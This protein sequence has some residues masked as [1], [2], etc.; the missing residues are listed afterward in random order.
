MV[1]RNIEEALNLCCVQVHCQHT[2]STGSSDEV[3]NQFCRDR[4]SGFC[5]SVLSCVAEI[6]DNGSHTA[7]RGA[8]EGIDHN[9]QFHEVIVDRSTGGLYNEHVR[10]TDRLLDRYSD[11]SVREC[12][13]L[14]FAYRQAQTSRN[15]RCYLWIGISSEDLDILTMQIHFFL[16]PLTCSRQIVS[17][18]LFTF[19]FRRF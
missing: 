1:Y 8:F 5:F 3:C 12:L 15:F 4:V 2:V 9:K 14:A 19:L 16:T 6:W 10:T 17:A 13:D 7:G 18:H 11:L